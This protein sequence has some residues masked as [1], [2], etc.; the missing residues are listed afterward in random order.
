M[1]FSAGTGGL[2]LCTAHNI[3][4]DTPIENVEALFEAYRDLARY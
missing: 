3:Q 4:A 1:T 2:I